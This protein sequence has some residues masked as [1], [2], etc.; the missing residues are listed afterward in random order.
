LTG[1]QPKGERS[2]GDA[3]M[4][5]GAAVRRHSMAALRSVINI[6]VS[7]SG[8]LAFKAGFDKLETFGSQR[9]L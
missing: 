3:A 9:E 2:R 4:S 8:R 1:G 5:I 6:P 7:V